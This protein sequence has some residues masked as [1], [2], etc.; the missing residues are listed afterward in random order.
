M[1]FLKDF[2]KTSSTA[3]NINHADRNDIKTI[4]VSGFRKCHHNVRRKEGS[5]EKTLGKNTTCE[6]RIKF[7]LRKTADHD[8]AEDCELFAL[9]IVLDYNHNHSI[10][11]AFAVKYHNVHDEVKEAFNKLFN[12]NHSAASAFKEYKNHLMQI[13]GNEYVKVSADRAIMPDYKWVFNQHAQYIENT[14]GKINS[15]E[16]FDK[17]VE[18]VNAYNLKNDEVLCSIKQSDDGEVIVAVCDQLSQRVHKV[19]PQSGDI[20]YVD[21]TSNLGKNSILFYNTW[22]WN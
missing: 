17:A 5:K 13:H 7:K 6:A 22:F 4:L 16:A 21:A 1:D 12:E 10:E 18:K 20:V 2:E 3:Y 15:P 9:N 11:S 14:L 8:H 19:L